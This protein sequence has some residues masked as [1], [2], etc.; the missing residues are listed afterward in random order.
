MRAEMPAPGQYCLPHVMS[1][2]L[3]KGQSG[4]F[5]GMEFHAQCMPSP[6]CVKRYFLITKQPLPQY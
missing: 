6:M 1:L 2:C 3:L 5:S 4:S